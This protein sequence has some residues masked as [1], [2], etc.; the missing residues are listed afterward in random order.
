MKK[1][2]TAYEL[3]MERLGGEKPLSAEQK[4]RLA[5]LDRVYAAREAEARLKS[6]EKMKAAGTDAAKQDAVRGELAR[7]LTRLA[8]KRESE[9][10]KARQA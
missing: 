4:E 6:D 2:K 3:A 5:E 8:A 1:M 10:E 9:R 7:E